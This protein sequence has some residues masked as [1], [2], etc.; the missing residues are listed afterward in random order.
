M[1]LFQVIMRTAVLLI[2]LYET[3]ASKIETM[4]VVLS[5]IKTLTLFVLYFAHLSVMELIAQNL[6]L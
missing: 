6:F 4:I 3:S 1:F 2:Y 5:D